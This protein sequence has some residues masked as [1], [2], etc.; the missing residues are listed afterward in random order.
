MHEVI[1][2]AL[3]CFLFF[4]VRVQTTNDSA[5]MIACCQST[6]MNHTGITIREQV[7]EEDENDEGGDEAED[8]E[9]QYEDR[10]DQDDD[11]RDDLEL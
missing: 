10:A 8:T 7:D 11:E 6:P 5:F 4:D 2:S 9:E 1:D 3:F